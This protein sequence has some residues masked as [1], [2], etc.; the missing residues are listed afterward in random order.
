[1]RSVYYLKMVLYISGHFV[2]HQFFIFPSPFSLWKLVFIFTGGFFLDRLF[3]IGHTHLVVSIS[4]FKYAFYLMLRLLPL[5]LPPGGQMIA[6]PNFMILHNFP[7]WCMHVMISPICIRDA[8]QL[9]SRISSRWP[10]KIA[11]TLLEPPLLLTRTSN[12][13]IAEVGYVCLT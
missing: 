12:G 4:S 3:Y 10:F 1:M 6:V 8:S 5:W 11:L 13:C 9:C 7:G 2:S